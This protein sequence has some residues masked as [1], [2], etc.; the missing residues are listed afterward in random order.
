MQIDLSNIQIRE[1]GIT[2]VELL[3]TYRMA[4]LTELQGEQ[5]EEYQEKLKKELTEYFTQALND[6]RFFAF[7]AE[8]KG[9]EGDS[10]ILL[11]PENK[12]LKTPAKELKLPLGEIREAKIVIKIN[13]K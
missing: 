5:S 7:M 11:I 12:K 1:I 2:E 3:T 8:L 13:N 4:Y 10:V 9:V 6:K